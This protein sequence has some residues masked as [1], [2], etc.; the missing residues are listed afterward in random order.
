MGVGQGRGEPQQ[1]VTEE[2]RR[3]E[4]A[5]GLPID[6]AGLHRAQQLVLP[7][8]A[9]IGEELFDDL[10]APAL[11]AWPEPEPPAADPG[12]EAFAL[13]LLARG[14]D[15]FAVSSAG[16]PPLLLAVRL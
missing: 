8:A 1:A 15:P 4:P 13:E 16:E 5:P 9:Q 11:H 10:D 14:A 12:G 2:A 3:I 6:L 7:L